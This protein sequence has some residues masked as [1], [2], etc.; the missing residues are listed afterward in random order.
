MEATLGQ[1]AT[2]VKQDIDFF[3]DYVPPLFQKSLDQG[4]SNI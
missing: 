3:M 2:K 4:K 1:K